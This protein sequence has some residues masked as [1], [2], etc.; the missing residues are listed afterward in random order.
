MSYAIEYKKQSSQ[1]EPILL[2]FLLS[3]LGLNYNDFESYLKLS[4]TDTCK[5]SLTIP[6]F[7]QN[8][9]HSTSFSM[10]EQAFLISNFI[11]DQ[12]ILVPSVKAISIYAFSFAADLMLRVIP[13]LST[14]NISLKKIVFCD[15]NINSNSAFITR[16]LE[17]SSVQTLYKQYLSQFEGHRPLQLDQSM[18]KFIDTLSNVS[19]KQLI[20]SSNEVIKN[21]NSYVD[22]ILR[23][24][25]NH[26]CYDTKTLFLFSF[27]DHALEITLQESFVNLLT[28]NPHLQRLYESTVQYRL[29]DGHHFVYTEDEVI[30]K[31][32]KV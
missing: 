24:W 6:G 26:I 20:V 30:E 29:I 5:I 7:E 15:I 19:P 3:G 9:D 21:I 32:L 17:K 22:L 2:Q 28:D 31:L 1:K 27:T 10:D 16:H 4:S 23:V 14:Q 25:K 11:N 18:I 12:I 8:L 13:L